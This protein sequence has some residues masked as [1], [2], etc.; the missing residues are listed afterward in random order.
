[1]PYFKVGFYQ[2]TDY[3]GILSNSTGYIDSPGEYIVIDTGNKPLYEILDTA[4]Q[5]IDDFVFQ[6]YSYG[7]ANELDVTLRYFKEGTELPQ[8]L[9]MLPEQPDPVKAAK[10]AL[11]NLISRGTSDPHD[12]TGGMFYF[13]INRLD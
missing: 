2:D 13:K 9:Q 7:M 1:M 6:I 5:K 4:T 11:E 3:T 12:G 10:K 8:I